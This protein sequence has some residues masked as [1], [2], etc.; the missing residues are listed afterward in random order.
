MFHGPAAPIESTNT[1]QDIALK[2]SLGAFPEDGKLGL[3]DQTMDVDFGTF[4]VKAEVKS[5]MFIQINC[6]IFLV[7]KKISNKRRRCY[8]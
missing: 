5:R 7:S 1:Q 3:K 6:S 4:N 2:L 8:C